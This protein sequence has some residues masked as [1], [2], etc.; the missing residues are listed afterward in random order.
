MKKLVI[1]FAVLTG[2]VMGFTGVRCESAG[3]CI[4]L[5]NG[6]TVPYES[7]EFKGDRARID[8]GKGIVITIP[9]SMIAAVR[10]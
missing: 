10:S 3:K 6:R 8:H 9:R 1:V 2:L 4:R 7:I 5:T